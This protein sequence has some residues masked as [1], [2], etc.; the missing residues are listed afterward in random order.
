MAEERWELADGDQPLQR[1]A[2]QRRAARRAGC[3]ATDGRI[4]CVSSMSGIAGNA[5]QTN[6]A[7]SKAGRDRHGRGDGAGARRARR[8]DQ[9]R[10][11]RLHRD[12]DD[13][14]DADRP[15]RGGPAD[16]LAV[17]GRPAGR[18]RRD[19]RLVRQPRLDRAS[20]ATWSASAARACSGPDVAATARTLDGSPSILPLYAP[21]RGA[22][23]PRRGLGRCRSSPAAAARS[24]R[25]RARAAEA[26]R[27]DAERRRR[28]L[29][30]L[31][32]HAAR[33]RCRPPTRTCSPS[34]CRWR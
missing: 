32:L 21:R 29:P 2:D 12:A 34:R 28:L 5:G 3:C 13:R 10:R 14:G 9:R 6:Y 27:A 7:T 4:V 33:R 18:R 24:P 25:A 15:A 16:E 26:S 11:A 20:T 23:G 30:G 31:R 1:G 19:D 17:P 22:A 8:D